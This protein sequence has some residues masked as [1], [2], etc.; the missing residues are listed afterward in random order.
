M[1]RA[2][3]RRAAPRSAPRRPRSPHAAISSDARRDRDLA[4]AGARTARP[5]PGARRRPSVRAE[6]RSSQQQSESSQLIT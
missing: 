5:P 4:H 3:R 2:A 6:Q 1:R